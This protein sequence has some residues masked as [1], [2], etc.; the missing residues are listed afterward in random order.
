MFD[1]LNVPCGC[2]ADYSFDFKNLRSGD[3]D[4]IMFNY[5]PSRSGYVEENIFIYF[6]GYKTPI[7]L[8]IK[9]HVRK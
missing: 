2:L 5:I 1:Y 9:A 6:V 7:H 8:L 3:T 4:S